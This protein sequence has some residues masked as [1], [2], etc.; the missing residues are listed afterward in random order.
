MSAFAQVTLSGN[1]DVAY[2][3]VGFDGVNSGTSTVVRKAQT[4]ASNSGTAST[5]S[6]NIEAIEDIGGGM[7]T[8]VRLEIDPRN[9]ITD[10]AGAFA[11]NQRYIGAS[12]DFGVF[13]IGSMDSSAVNANGQQ[14]ALG[15]GIG[16]GYGITQSSVFAATRYNRSV[17]YSTPTMSGF[18]GTI[19]Y[20]PGV[21]A[22]GT[23]NVS[24]AGASDVSGL[25]FQRKVT[26]F[27]IAYANGPLAA[28]YININ[29][30]QMD[31]AS[32]ASVIVP[33]A[34]TTAQS[35]VS[36]NLLTASYEMGA[37][38]FYFGYNKGATLGTADSK[39]GLYY[40]PALAA[41]LDTK[42]T[43]LGYKY[44]AGQYDLMLQTGRQVIAND[45]AASTYHT[46]KV[47]GFRV[48]N[49]I[50]KTS[51]VY[52]GYEGYT[53]GADLAA[54]NTTNADGGKYSLLSFG[55]KKSF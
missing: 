8:M 4:I 32:A 11:L 54:N 1:V 12:G 22:S 23:Q 30:G 29:A 50:S 51:A 48:V 19:L 9:W 5:S 39:G 10:A 52:V 14:S 2:T 46:R 37:N 36:S 35:S 33:I 53:S 44:T 49:N 28:T 38:K 40:V 20:A 18:T 34:A 31:A 47:S 27:A 6:I 17:S 13:K 26:E 7:K 16:S 55:I 25:P 45:A 43:K 15:T 41:N 42:G 21:Q 24:Y 3:N